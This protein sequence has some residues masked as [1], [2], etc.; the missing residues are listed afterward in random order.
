M[1]A[2]AD[3]PS[4]SPLPPGRIVL[5]GGL[6]LLALYAALWALVPADLALLKKL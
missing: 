3:H 5:V 4:G 6:V 1:T 2:I